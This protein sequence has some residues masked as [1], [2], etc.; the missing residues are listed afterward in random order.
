MKI[1][2]VDDNGNILPMNLD[3][4]LDSFISKDYEAFDNPFFGTEPL[5]KE[6]SQLCKENIQGMMKMMTAYEKEA[7]TTAATL[8]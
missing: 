5:S 6:E 7:E 2:L 4:F 3:E 8:V 1:I